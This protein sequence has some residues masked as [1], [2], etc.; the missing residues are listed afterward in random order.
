MFNEKIMFIYKI[1]NVY[2]IPKLFFDASNAFDA[3]FFGLNAQSVRNMEQEEV[4][5]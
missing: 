1:F 5:C 3:N 4:R 2:I